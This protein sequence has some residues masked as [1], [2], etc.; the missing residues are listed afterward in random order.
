MNSPIPYLGGKSRL[1]Q[2]ILRRLPDHTCYCEPF[3]GSAKILFAKTPSKC[4]VLNDAD[5][6]LVTFVADADGRFQAT[7]RVPQAVLELHERHVT[8]A[9]AY[10]K[11]MLDVLV[12]FVKTRRLG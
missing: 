3:C 1:A 8:E 12:D 5:G 4:E 9:I 11:Q 2:Q 6:E 10:R 7:L